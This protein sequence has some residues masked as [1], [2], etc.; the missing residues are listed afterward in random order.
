MKFPFSGLSRD[1]RNG[2][3]VVAFCLLVFGAVKH[4][5]FPGLFPSPSTSET[6]LS[7]EEWLEVENFER[8]RRADSLQREKEWQAQR[9]QWQREKEERRRAREQRQERYAAQRARWEA[10]KAERKAEQA[11]RRAHYDSLLA[12]RPKKLKPGEFVDA[13]DAD[14]LLLQRIPGIGS[15]YARVIVSYRERL[16]GFVSTSQLSEI[17]G[18]P[19]NIEVWFRVSPTPKIRQVSINRATFKE[20][21]RHPYLSYEQVKIIVTRRQKQGQLHGWDELRNNSLFTEADFVRLRPYFYF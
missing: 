6:Q 3:L 21:V 2:L 7:R 8:Q 5:L 14:T 18:L 10:E 19:A 16:G 20:L 1:L 13:N 15:V 9:E 11:A 17:A 4:G 12:L